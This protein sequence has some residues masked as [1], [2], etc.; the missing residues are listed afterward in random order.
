M[1]DALARFRQI[2]NEVKPHSALNRR[3]PFSVLSPELPPL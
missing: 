3:T 1:C 2:Y